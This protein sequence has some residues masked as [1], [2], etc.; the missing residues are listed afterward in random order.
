MKTLKIILVA[1]VSIVVVCLVGLVVYGLFFGNKIDWTQDIWRE[2]WDKYTNEE[3]GFSFEYPPAVLIEEE[4]PN[5]SEYKNVKK[6]LSLNSRGEIWGLIYILSAN[7]IIRSKNYE[8]SEPILINNQPVEI[9]GGKVQKEINLTNDRTQ[10]STIVS[11]IILAQNRDLKLR[12]V[13]AFHLTD[14]EKQRELKEKYFDYIV[15]SLKSE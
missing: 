1:I 8:R 15:A 2:K 7:E 6:T 14:N 11:E 5:I 10:I 12:F 3:Y 4:D 13:M 9:N